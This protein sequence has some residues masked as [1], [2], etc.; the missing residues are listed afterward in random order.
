MLPLP[1]AL[2]QCHQFKKKV[3]VHCIPNG[4]LFVEA[5]CGLN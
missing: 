1:Y 3:A 5:F 4:M 2:A